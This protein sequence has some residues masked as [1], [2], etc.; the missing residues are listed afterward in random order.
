MAMVIERLTLHKQRS[1]LHAFPNYKF[2]Q[3]RRHAHEKLWLRTILRQPPHDA[4]RS[5]V[6]VQHKVICHSTQQLHFLWKVVETYHHWLAFT[7]TI[8][9]KVPNFVLVANQTTSVS[10]AHCT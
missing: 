1:K 10:L 2:A 7:T 4:V 6:S 5:V 8:G 3:H 9:N